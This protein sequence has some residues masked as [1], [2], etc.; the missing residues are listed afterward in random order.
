MLYKVIKF[1]IPNQNPLR[2][3]L[4]GIPV[5]NFNI[6][7]SFNNN[8]LKSLILSYIQMGGIQM[9]ITC[10]SK[11]DLLDAYKNPGNHENLIVRVG[12][13]SEYFCRLSDKI[14]QM[15]IDRTIQNG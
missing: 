15:I 10:T 12:G 9:Q 11:A 1:L 8:I 13:Y 5:L 6:E 2:Y 3:L 14:K 7:S 4:G